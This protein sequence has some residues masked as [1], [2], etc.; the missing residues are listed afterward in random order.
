M[1]LWNSVVMNIIYLANYTIQTFL[2]CVCNYLCVCK[3]W[4]VCKYC[5]CASMMC[6]QGLKHH[7]TL[8]AAEPFCLQK[9]LLIITIKKTL[10]M[11]IYNCIL[12]G[13]VKQ[14]VKMTKF[15]EFPPSTFYLYQLFV[16]I[17]RLRGHISCFFFPSC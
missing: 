15:H 10:F 1:F 3:Y 12:F 9:K 5:V 16:Q 4:C 14:S 7:Q 6:V 11:F 13:T 8:K 2:V 17:I